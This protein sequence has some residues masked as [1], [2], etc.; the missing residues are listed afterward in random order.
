VNG[1]EALAR[2]GDEVAA[3]LSGGGLAAAGKPRRAC[4]QALARLVQ[5]GDFAFDIVS[6]ATK[7]PRGI[8]QGRPGLQ[9]LA[10]DGK[11]IGGPRRPACSGGWGEFAQHGGSLNAKISFPMRGAFLC[12]MP[13]CAGTHI[14]RG[15]GGRNECD[16]GNRGSSPDELRFPLRT[17]PSPSPPGGDGGQQAPAVSRRGLPSFLA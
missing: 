7:R 12:C 8:D 17:V 16:A 1:A 14:A 6:S 10:Q 9:M 3:A 4:P 15:K 2:L 5:L 13:G 11:I